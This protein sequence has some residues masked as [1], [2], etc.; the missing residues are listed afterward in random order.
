M[1]EKGK[2]A[3]A[4]V[5]GAFIKLV[6]GIILAAVFL[7]VGWLAFEAIAK[8]LVGALKDTG[9]G[10]LAGGVVVGVSIVVGATVLSLKK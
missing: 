4:P 2:I 9:L 8:N 5:V 10:I 6:V 3:A 7:G 1:A